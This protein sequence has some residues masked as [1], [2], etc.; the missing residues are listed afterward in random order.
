[1]K[2]ILSAEEIEE[3]RKNGRE[4]AFEYFT[5]NAF[6]DDA[7]IAQYLSNLENALATYEEKNQCFNQWDFM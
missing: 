2:N 4:K 3:R 6:G 5:K 1:L 7:I